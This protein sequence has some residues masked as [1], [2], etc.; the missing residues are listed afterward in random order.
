MF[1]STYA[2]YAHVF[3]HYGSQIL[4]ALLCGGVIGLEREL[5]NKAAGIKTN[6]LICLGAALYTSTSIMITSEAAGNALA[7][8]S[9]IAAQIVSGIGFLGGGTIIQSRG[10][11]TG[12]T[13]AATIWV[14]AAIGVCIGIGHA[15][16]AVAWT[17]A[18]LLV[19]I[20]TSIFEDRILGRTLNFTCMVVFTDPSSESRLSVNQA[21]TENDLTLGDFN[22]SSHLGLSTMTLHYTGHRTKNRK[23]VLDLWHIPGIREVRQG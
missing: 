20:L 8:P 6:M 10:A 17:L 1:A 18:V 12:L 13:T 4:Y 7:D 21:L 11:I 23:F 22:I 9:R 14:V 2:A 19:L 5:K 15:E 3:F 16:L